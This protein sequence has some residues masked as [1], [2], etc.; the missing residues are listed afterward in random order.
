MP[1]NNVALLA[2]NRGI[3]SPLALARTD[4]E[5]VALSAEV[6]TNFVPRLLGSMM[7]RPGFGYIGRTFNDSKAR[8]IPFVF[9]TEDTALL[10]FT[11]SKMRVW[12]D[13]ALIAR[14]S[15]STAI[16]N[17][18]FSG[19]LTGWTDASGTDSST[20]VV[21]FGA[22]LLGNGNTSAVLYQQVAVGISDLN[23]GHSILIY[24]PRG[25]VTLR[26]GSSQGADD[27]MGESTLFEGYHSISFTPSGDFFIQF[28]SSN[29]YP[30]V[31]GSV[32]VESG[33]TF[34]ITTPWTEA[35]LAYIQ[36][37]QSADVLFTGCPGYQQ[38]R[39][40]R[41]DNSSWSV[42]K[43][44]SDDGPFEL[45]NTTGTQISSS[46]LSGEVTLT[47]TDDVFRSGHVGALFRLQSNGQQV[48][49]SLTG[50]NQFT[51]YIEVT[52]IDDSR[53]FTIVLSTSDSA[54]ATLTLQYSVGDP[55]AWVDVE[56]YSAGNSSHTYNDGYDNSTI[57][58]RIGIKSGDYTSGTVTA[59]LQ[60]PGGSI[61]GI[62]R[63]S[64]VESSTV[65]LGLVIKNLGNTTATSDW[66][67]GSFSA[68][69]GFPSAV[70]IYEGRLWWAGSDRIYGS[71]SDAYMSFD[72]GYN[73]DE[74]EA[75]DA[76]GISYSIGYGPV[77]TVNWLLPLLRL[78]GGTQGSEASIQSSSYGEVLTPSNFHIKYPSTQ[79]S[80]SAGAVVLDN[81]GIFAHRSGRRVYE[82]NYSSDFYDYASNDLTEMWPECGDSE[83]IRIAAHRLPDDRIHC[84]RAD[85]T[86]ALLVRD[87]SEDMR[88]WVV[89]ETDG[90][91]EDVVTLPGDEEDRVYYVVNRDGFRCLERWA[92]ESECVGGD[93]NKNA[94]CYTSGSN[95]SELTGLDHLE[96]KSLIAWADGKDIG[97]F[98]VSS[99]S[100]SLGATYGNVIAGLGYT[101][102][103]KSS[104]LAYAAGMGTALAQRKSVDH[105]ALI[106]R[107][108]HAQGLQY[109]PDFTRLDDMP[110][111]E[112]GAYVDDGK[113]WE[114]YD[115]DSFE[116]DGMWD[117]DSRI[118]LQAAAPRPVTL[119]AAVIS[120][121][122][123]DK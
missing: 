85:G 114:S 115:K 80:N 89:I 59:A 83:I 64:A 109:G 4:I 87:P 18:T 120:I 17:G 70:A 48:S 119:L 122:T 33:G 41:R 12:V 56:T 2:F 121:A 92:K 26:I 42:V 110:R 73:S 5:R 112:D 100:L 74:L 29:T 88:A 24:I 38:Y 20:A 50:A 65:A 99:G 35:D 66:Y 67:E 82:L 13:D 72:D 55:G 31:V 10:E 84:V 53:E 28:S 103:Y 11:D 106:M 75:G 27:Y 77:D 60:F 71:Y 32:S 25:P 43:Y 21:P 62:V 54:V 117:T 1:R 44:Y 61:T 79:G 102:Q 52:G 107:N 30:V 95:V 68:V 98:T 118:C 6:Q 69:K 91:I 93:I 123:H 111:F 3:I 15:V 104:K 94:D 34:A 39:I 16:T 86:V 8:F 9:A 76:S 46:A 49:S 101:A 36:V 81:R 105:L 23:V 116:F 7:L 108:T 90:T 78:I 19:S 113:V 14:D 47:A 96:G 63:I 45:L 57:Y 97:T 40:E 22:Q 51:D 37:A 58:Y